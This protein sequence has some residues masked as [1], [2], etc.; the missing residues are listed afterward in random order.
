[1]VTVNGIDLLVDVMRLP[2]YLRPFSRKVLVTYHIA[3]A[4]DSDSADYDSCDCPLEPNS[5]LYGVP[6]KLE[7]DTTLFVSLY[8]L[9]GAWVLGFHIMS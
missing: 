4:G 7:P 9:V 1:M 3:G 6:I 2:G 8:I 5:P